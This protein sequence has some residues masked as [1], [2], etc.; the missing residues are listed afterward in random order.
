MA[1]LAAELAGIIGSQ[2]ADPPDD[3][4][5]VEGS[6]I[7]F[8]RARITALLEHAEAR[9]AELDAAGERVNEGTFGRCEVCGRHVGEERLAAVPDTRRC[10]EC[11]RP[12]TRGRRLGGPL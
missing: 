10:V 5:D 7:G 1:D 4:H 6:S 8:E 3:E 12:T 2:A 9:L 11:A